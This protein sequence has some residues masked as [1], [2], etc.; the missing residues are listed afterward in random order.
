MR[1]LIW[2]V[3]GEFIKTDNDLT[4]EGFREALV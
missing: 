1:G 2:D 3:C 4:T